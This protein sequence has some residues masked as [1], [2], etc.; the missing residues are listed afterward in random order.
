MLAF[1]W[2]YKWLLIVGLVVA[3]GAG[4]SAG[5]KVENLSFDSR[6]SA[7]YATQT[8][9]LLSSPR[10]SAYQAVVPGQV[11]LEN[12]TPTTSVDLAKTAVIYA[13]IASGSAT[14]DIVA[15]EIGALGSDESMSAVQRTTQPGDPEP[16]SAD[17]G[18]NR[19]ALPVL[20][21]DTT[22]AT[23]ERAQDIADA[24]FAALNRQVTEQQDA[25]ALAPDL[26]VTLSVIDEQTFET[27]SGTSIVPS[28][29]TA[30]AV[31]AAFLVLALALNNYR[32]VRLERTRSR[33][34]S[35]GTRVVADPLAA[36]FTEDDFDFEKRIATEKE[37]AR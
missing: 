12:E 10:T 1:V 25:A 36:E 18:M 27:S 31:F 28:A 15:D 13:Y 4:V 23:A 22:A 24:T 21:I 16:K 32:Q 19:L 33:R 29:V 6:A 17:A 7:S 14:R 35:R 34:E 3:L 9:V 2:Q 30:V 8:T 5:Y 26:R 11:L 20:A 37:G